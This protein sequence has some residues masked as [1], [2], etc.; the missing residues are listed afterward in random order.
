[1]EECYRGRKIENK[2]IFPVKDPFGR[3]VGLV[4]RSIESKE[5]KVFVTE[6]AK[7]D[8]FFFGLYQALPHIYERNLVYVVEGSFDHMAIVKVLPNTVATLTANLSD[9]QYDLLMMYCDKIIT[10]FDSDKA[11][12]KAREKAEE[13]KNVGSIY[14]GY[15]DPAKCLEEYG[16]KYFKEYVL[17]KASEVIL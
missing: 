5:F 12:N 7:F 9:A 11:G 17:K 4:G 2:L 3:N 8:G 13:R 10:I 1:M 16:F 14:F 6:Q 15:K